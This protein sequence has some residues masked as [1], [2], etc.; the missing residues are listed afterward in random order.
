[1]HRHAC[2]SSNWLT[3]TI[4]VWQ[5]FQR[6]I[7]LH[8]RAL[9]SPGDPTSKFLVL[10]PV[11]ES[12]NRMLAIVTGFLFS[13]LSD[14]ALVVNNGGFFASLKDLWEKPGF[15]W[16]PSKYPPSSA[17]RKTYF[18]F[19]EERRDA[20]WMETLQC[21][22][23][24]NITAKTILFRGNQCVDARPAR[25]MLDAARMNVLAACQVHGSDIPPQPGVRTP[26]ARAVPARH[27]RHHC[28]IL[29]PTEP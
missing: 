24:S 19:S 21:E 2:G 4:L 22:D 9:A 29:V 18:G 23:W 3:H 13:L 10:K 27:V 5:A 8:R 12:G 15:D 1:M 28:S 11:A 17:G 26:R 14:R 6:Y 25:G 20:M 16:T 7:Q